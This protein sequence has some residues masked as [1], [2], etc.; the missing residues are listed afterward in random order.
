MDN[1]EGASPN[2]TRYA[3]GKQQAGQI[4]NVIDVG[5]GQKDSV[6]LSEI[7]TGTGQFLA[8]AGPT[9]DQNGG[10]TV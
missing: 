6:H 9:I 7:A 1:L 8:D 3:Q 4:G 5:V 10:V 2:E